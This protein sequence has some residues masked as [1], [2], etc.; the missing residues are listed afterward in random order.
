[1]MKMM[2]S[3]MMMLCC[4]VRIFEESQTVSRCDWK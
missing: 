1:M 2:M 4:T 3:A